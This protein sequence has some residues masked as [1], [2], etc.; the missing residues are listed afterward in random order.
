MVTL[1]WMDGRETDHNPLSLGIAAG[2]LPPASMVLFNGTTRV[3]LLRWNVGHALYR[4]TE[5]N[6]Q[7]VAA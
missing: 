4:V 1:I 7:G 2:S 5:Y 3:E 6:W